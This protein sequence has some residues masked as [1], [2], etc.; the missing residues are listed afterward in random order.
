MEDGNSFLKHHLR[1]EI[2]QKCADDQKQQCP[3]EGLGSEQRRLHRGDH[4]A[5]HNG[6]A[7]GKA[8]EKH[9]AQWLY[10]DHISGALH[11]AAAED[12]KSKRGKDDA[13]DGQ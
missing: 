4:V 2:P 11:F 12:K 9:R 10:R 1:D 13:S 6:A 7:D 3:A 8:V 5:E